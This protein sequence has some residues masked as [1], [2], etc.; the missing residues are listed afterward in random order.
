VALAVL[1][2]PIVRAYVL[3]RRAF[4]FIRQS[5]S[6]QRAACFGYHDDEALSYGYST[7]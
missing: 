1:N 2:V 3:W 6:A 5:R 7:I 4:S